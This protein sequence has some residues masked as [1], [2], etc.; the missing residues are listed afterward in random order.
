MKTPN[1]DTIRFLPPGLAK[2]HGR[3]WTAAAIA[4]ATG[5]SPDAVCKTLR[6]ERRGAATQI[7]I[8]NC[9]GLTVDDLFADYANPLINRIRESEA[10]A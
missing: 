10:A 2:S 6:G 4:R 1:D 8:A 3:G 9:I 5:L 7:A